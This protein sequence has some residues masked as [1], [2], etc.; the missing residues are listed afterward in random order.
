MLTSKIHLLF[1]SSWFPD[2]ENPSLGNFVVKHLEILTEVTNLTLLQVEKIQDCDKR[3]QIE[4]SEQNGYRKVHV[5][6]SASGGFLSKYLNLIRYIRAYYQGWKKVN[7]YYGK[8]EIIHANV[9]YPVGI[10]CLLAKYIYGLPYVVSEHWTVYMK[11]DPVNLSRPEQL[12]IQW[13]ARKA[14]YVMPV[15]ESLMIEMQKYGI[16]A[17]WKVVPNV[18]NPHVFYPNKE[19]IQC[20]PKQIFHVSSFDNCQKN[21]EGILKATV[22]LLKYRT[23]FVLHIAGDGDLEEVQ[24]KAKELDLDSRYLKFSSSMSHE[25]IANEL[26]RSAF[27]VLFSNFESFSVVLAESIACGCPVV[28]SKCGGLT[29][30]MPIFGG[31]QVESGNIQQLCDSM[32]YMLDHS[33]EYPKDKMFHWVHLQFSPEVIRN[34]FLEIYKNTLNQ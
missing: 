30:V 34:E 14:S 33:F 20:N 23:D 3:F 15:S 32:N 29:D 1:I 10:I 12:I 11:S 8:P 26:N 17:Q 19:A 2:R 13:A 22:L 18:I 16:N 31:L 28:T 9:L 24:N 7:T 27:F 5:L 21:I 4:V 25:A 6:Y